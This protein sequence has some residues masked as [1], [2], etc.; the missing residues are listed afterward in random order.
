MER[1]VVR[2][3]HQLVPGMII[4]LAATPWRRFAGL[5]GKKTMGSG[6]GLWIKPC[7]QIHTHWMQFPIDLIFIDS[8]GKVVHQLTQNPG[9]ISRRILKAESVLEFMAGTVERLAIHTGDTL[10]LTLM[11]EAGGDKI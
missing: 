11:N 1:Y 2:L 3:N 9:K 6:Q 5:L 4:E 10:E 7:Q 8:T